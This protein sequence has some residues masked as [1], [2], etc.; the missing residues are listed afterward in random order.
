M[1]FVATTGYADCADNA[2]GAHE[3]GFF[4]F[5]AD[6]TG[7]ALRGL[8]PGIK[9]EKQPGGPP[10]QD[11]PVCLYS[12]AASLA[13]TVAKEFTATTHARLWIFAPLAPARIDTL[14]QWVLSHVDT[15]ECSWG[16]L[17]ERAGAA[18]SAHDNADAALTIGAADLLHLPTDAP[19]LGNDAAAWLQE[20][21]TIGMVASQDGGGRA[22]AWLE[23]HRIGVRQI[24]MQV[25]ERLRTAAQRLGRLD[26]H[27]PHPGSVEDR[28]EW[29][30]ACAVVLAC[31]VVPEPS[32]LVYRSER[33]GRNLIGREEL[34]AAGLATDGNAP[35]YRDR[36][37][38][39][40][41]AKS[42]LKEHVVL[43]YAVKPATGV[44]TARDAADLLGTY[45]AMA[46]TTAQADPARLF[47]PHGVI[48][49]AA[50][51]FDY[52]TFLRLPEIANT[53]P[54]QRARSLAQ[55]MTEGGPTVLSH[56]S[57][58][59][60]ANPLR[61]DG[62]MAGYK[63]LLLTESMRGDNPSII[64]EAISMVQTPGYD[65]LNVLKVL[66]CGTSTLEP[67]RKPTGLSHQLAVGILPAHSIDHRLAPVA[68]M[69]AEHGPSYLGKYVGKKL[70]ALGY[71]TAEQ[72]KALKYIRLSKTLFAKDD[73]SDFV[74]DMVVTTQEHIHTSQSPYA[75]A[76]TRVPAADRYADLFINLKMPQ[77]LHAVF[78][79]VGRHFSGDHSL[80]QVVEESNAFMAFN[81]GVT[82][83]STAFLS[84]AQQALFVGVFS[85]ENSG[86]TPTLDVRNPAAAIPPV[87]LRG[88]ADEGA[89]GDF[90][91]KQILA[92][93]AS[94][95]RQSR[96][97]SETLDGQV[98]MPTAAS[99]VSM[100]GGG[101]A[102]AA[103]AHGDAN[104][105]K[106][107]AEAAAEAKAKKLRDT[108]W[109]SDAERAEMGK[110]SHAGEKFGFDDLGDVFYCGK[111]RW[112]AKKAAQDHPNLC[113]THF[114]LSSLPGVAGVDHPE[115][116]DDEHDEAHK[117]PGATAHKIPD[118]TKASSYRIR[119]PWTGDGKGA[120]G[121]KGGKGAG[122]GK[123]GGKGKSSGG[124]GKGKG[125][126][127]GN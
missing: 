118:G 74:N 22:L 31:S 1:P 23:S 35:Y 34:H 18:A 46:L 65:V 26:A 126:G 11:R 58:G 59:S 71:V 107:K 17:A 5:A 115:G 68:T 97:L 72:V 94:L 62:G 86:Y 105:K 100:C 112:D 52:A 101:G 102:A 54:E 106:R 16:G 111:T 81:V 103:H 25:I 13:Y 109:P 15:T 21:F 55:K 9:W 20:Q 113:L 91:R 108:P 90:A 12:D 53:R 69:W 87:Q 40:V 28:T 85:E 104:E 89:R 2:W 110:Y 75:T 93:R 82:A 76:M 116:C 43:A 44:L 49:L 60:Y 19:G 36:L 32:C 29:A 48:M 83:A 88:S 51:L 98:G 70:V 56:S 39:I 14:V 42:A 79:C 119:P 4:R 120:G 124:K 121:G 24:Q 33:S 7:Q 99:Y 122:G 10:G 125:K 38:A 30:A 96:A 45:G 67:N 84:A 92:Q 127:K 57:A 123:G 27:I 95:E 50:A 41:C 47:T 78:Q 80:R 8:C 37:A 73:P 64:A 117:G 6:E 114:F 63:Q 77:L 3:L 66:L 61:S